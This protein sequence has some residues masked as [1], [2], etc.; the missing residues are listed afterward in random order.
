MLLANYAEWYNVPE[1]SINYDTCIDC[2]TCVKICPMGVY[3]DEGDKVSVV[4]QD[5]CI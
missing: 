5:E 3:K 4:A 2:K 1:V